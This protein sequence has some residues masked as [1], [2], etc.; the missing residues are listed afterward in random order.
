M[1]AAPHPE[2]QR[3][4]PFLDHIGLV[5]REHEAGSSTCALT[6]VPFHLNSSGLV[7]GAVIFALADTG[8]GAALLG[9]LEEGETLATVD[10]QINYLR[11]VQ[12]GEL[13]CTTQLVNRGR[14]LAHLESS[15]YLGEA[16]VARAS[17]NFAIFR[18]GAR[19]GAGG[20]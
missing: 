2:R 4:F 5:V 11:P 18:R 14:T 16:L 7:H 6:V 17:G 1:D 19:G 20:A 13:T 9:T 12:G 3:R 15:I 10:L 8:M